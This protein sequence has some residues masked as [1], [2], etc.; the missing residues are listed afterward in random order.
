MAERPPEHR[1][2]PSRL[3][4]LGPGVRV[5]PAALRFTFVASGGPGGQNVNKR[6]TKAVLRVAVVDLGMPLD[7]AD[8]LRSQQSH[9]LTGEDELLIPCEVHRSQ[10]RNRAECVEL[11][12][13]AVVRALARPKPRRPTKPSRG[14]IERRLETKRQRSETKKRRRPP[15][16]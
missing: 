5:P 7:A 14:A 10:H 13:A 15:P 4:R 9:W 12:S 8:R 3:V 2:D 1:G 6:S 16:D 11:L